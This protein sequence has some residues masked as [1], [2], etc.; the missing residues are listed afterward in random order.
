MTTVERSVATSALRRSGGG[1]RDCPA[2]RS[3]VVPRIG[4]ELPETER[5]T[6][7]RGADTAG[8]ADA[9]GRQRAKWEV[10]QAQCQLAVRC[11]LPFTPLPPTSSAL[12][13][14]DLPFLASF[15]VPEPRLDALN[16][17]L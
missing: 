11:T 4:F 9:G 15:S 10:A 2:L 16:A 13:L 12:R 17:G 6:G 1:G 14:P 3:A 5:S 7:Q 8:P